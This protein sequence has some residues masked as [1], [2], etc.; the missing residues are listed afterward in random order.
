MSF[1][2][3]YADILLRADRYSHRGGDTGPVTRTDRRRYALDAWRELHFAISAGWQDGYGYTRRQLTL[4]AAGP[5]LTLP[6]NFL[7]LQAL[8]RDDFDRRQRVYRVDPTAA[9]ERGWYDGDQNPSSPHYFLEGPGEEFDENL[10]ADVPYPQRIRFFPDVPAGTLVTLGYRTQAPSLGDPTDDNDDV[11]QVDVIAEPAFA[12]LA[13][14]VR[15][16][17]VTR[18]EAKE[19][20]RARAKASEIAVQLNTLRGRQDDLGVLDA[21]DFGMGGH[22]SGY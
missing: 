6:N 13:N 8:R 16:G 2:A 21:D 20:Q 3:S 11:I 10:Q 5:T 7:S 19:L 14:E 9:E 22:V 15:I 1:P 17:M 18:E 12:W 4:T